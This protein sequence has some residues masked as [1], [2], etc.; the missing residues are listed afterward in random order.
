[1]EIKPNKRSRY[2]KAIKYSIPVFKLLAIP[3]PCAWLDSATARHIEHWEN[4]TKLKEK[5]TKKLIIILY[6]ISV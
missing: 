4:E 3:E 2:G 5:K 6:I 1:M